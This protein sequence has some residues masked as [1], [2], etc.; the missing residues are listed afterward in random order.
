MNKEN[1]SISNM[2]LQGF[3]IRHSGLNPDSNKYEIESNFIHTTNLVV[4]HNNLI[5]IYWRTLAYGK[6]DQMYVF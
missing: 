6:F 1:V 3:Y 5:T 2:K 4:F